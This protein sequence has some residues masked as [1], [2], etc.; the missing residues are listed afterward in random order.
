MGQPLG[1]KPIKLKSVAM[2]T[3]VSGYPQ[4]LISSRSPW[5]KHTLKIGKNPCSGLG[6]GTPTNYQTQK[7]YKCWPWQHLLPDTPK[8]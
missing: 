6:C 2:A 1:L 3:A 7:S 5:G 8:T 4:N